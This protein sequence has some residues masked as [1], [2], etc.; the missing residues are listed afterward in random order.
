MKNI[1]IRKMTLGLVLILMLPIQTFAYKPKELGVRN[2]TNKSQIL[3]QTDKNKR[4]GIASTG[5]KVILDTSYQDEY[6]NDP[7]DYKESAYDDGSE[8]SNDV[9][10]DKR[11]VDFESWFPDYSEFEIKD[12]NTYENVEESV[13]IEKAIEDTKQN[14]KDKQS[15]EIFGL[16]KRSKV[17]KSGNKILVITK[18]DVLPLIDN[19]NTYKVKTSEIQIPK[20]DIVPISDIK[21][22]KDLDARVKRAAKINKV[23]GYALSQQGK[24]YVWGAAG[25]NSFDC[26][27]LIV[28]SYRQVGITMPRTSYTQCYSGYPVKSAELR[29]GDCLYFKITKTSGHVG[30]YL[31]DGLFVHAPKEGDVVKVTSLKSGH[32]SQT[33]CGARRFIK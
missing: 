9:E 22:I 23:V 27:G 18:A 20:T 16:A 5:K 10:L 14:I 4:N 6:A 3:N 31:G 15:K 33:I 8:L 12:E 28:S 13:D 30:M 25:P 2:D 17:Y 21:D 7:V 11:D 26:S 24:P 29:P 19:S 1:Q 32:Y